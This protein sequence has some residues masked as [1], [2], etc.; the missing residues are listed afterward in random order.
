VIVV[1]VEQAFQ[2]CPKALIRS[3]L[4]RVA[5]AGRPK[6]VPTLGDFAAARTL[7]TD[8]ATFDADYTRRM[9]GELY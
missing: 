4:W 7:G 6:G 3:D 1:S 9:P 8:S 5:G 2:H